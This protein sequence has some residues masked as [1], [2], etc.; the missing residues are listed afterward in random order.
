MQNST[1][2][3]IIYSE[4]QPSNNVTSKETIKFL[5]IF[6]TRPDIVY[7]MPDMKDEITI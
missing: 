2:S 5:K 7:T 6:F 3:G 1:I 4:K